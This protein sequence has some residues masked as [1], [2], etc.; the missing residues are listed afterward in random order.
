MNQADLAAAGLCEQDSRSKALILKTLNIVTKILWLSAF[1]CA[2]FMCWVVYE[3][4]IIPDSSPLHAAMVYII[5]VQVVL[6]V[7]TLVVRTWV[8]RNWNQVAVLKLDNAN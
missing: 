3:G 5:A 4:P 2:L 1:Q 6:T 8:S 7:I